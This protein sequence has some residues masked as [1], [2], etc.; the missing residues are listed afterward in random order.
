MRAVFTIALKDLRQ[1]MRDRS[2]VV[3]S[4]VAPLAIATLM[5]FAFR[6]TETFHATIGLVDLDRGT[7]A[8]A[9]DELLARPELT[10]VITVRRF[11]TEAEARQAVDDRRVAAAWVLPADL[12]ASVTTGATADVRTLTD[13]NAAIAGEVATSVAQGFASRINAQGLAIA[14][15]LSN[16]SSTSPAELQSLLGT[17]P[18]SEQLVEQAAGTRELKGI[19]YYGPGMAIFFGFFTIGFTARSYFSDRREGMLD[20]V[21]A[22]PVHPFA[23]VVGKA[24]SA[25]VLTLTSLIVMGVVTTVALGADWGPRPAALAVC[26]A[27]ALSVTA[28]ATLVIAAARTERQS[29]GFSSLLVFGLALLGGNFVFMSA[30]PTL[31]RKLALITPNGWALRAFMDMST[32]AGGGAAVVPIIAILLVTLGATGLALVLR[33]W[34]P[35]T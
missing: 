35:A 28:L 15:A 5:S 19:N 9:F 27:M 10:S 31:V 22:A 29:E 13:V 23:V 2:A 8:G 6:G 20:R 24:L 30:A 1:R 25:F 11:A 33:Q 17:L 21:A 26:V 32:G 7:I 34:R 3:L 4:F 14:T 12:T 18:E 16:G